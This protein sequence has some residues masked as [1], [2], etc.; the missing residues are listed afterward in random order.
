MI[1]ALVPDADALKLVIFA[2]GGTWKR[3]I[4][5][6]LALAKFSASSAFKGRRG[7]GVW[8]NANPTQKAEIIK[9]RFIML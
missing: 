1:T 4:I 3:S 9:N 6:A 5:Q 7:T 2:C 8:P